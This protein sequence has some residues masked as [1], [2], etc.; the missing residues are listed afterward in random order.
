MEVDLGHIVNMAPLLFVSAML[1]SQVG[2]A[3]V[4][5][6]RKYIYILCA[7]IHKLVTRLTTMELKAYGKAGAIAEEVLSS[8]RTVFAYNGQQREAKRF[9]YYMQALCLS[10]C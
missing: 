3:S 8:I 6:C 9:E 2:F 5:L 7:H 10:Q 4:C 1:F